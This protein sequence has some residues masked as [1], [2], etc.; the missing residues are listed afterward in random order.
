MNAHHNKTARHAQH[1]FSIIM[2][3]PVLLH[4]TVLHVGAVGAVARWDVERSHWESGR[5]MSW[6]NSMRC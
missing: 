2:T 4:W 1:R 5:E 6:D 3:N